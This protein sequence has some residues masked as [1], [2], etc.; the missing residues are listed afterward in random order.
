MVQLVEQMLRLHQQI[1][2]ENV[3]NSK[4]IIQQQIKVTDKQINQL[5][6]E[7]Y[8]LTDEIIA[9]IEGY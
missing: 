9:I 5:V 7:L 8:D 4:K 3:P 1:N 2:Q 6:Y